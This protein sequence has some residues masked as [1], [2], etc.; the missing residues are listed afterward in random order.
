MSL[1]VLE[2]ISSRESDRQSL[3]A[4]LLDTSAVFYELHQR[5]WKKELELCKKCLTRLWAY[6]DKI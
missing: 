3:T 4:S 6:Y 1:K 5:D 2:R